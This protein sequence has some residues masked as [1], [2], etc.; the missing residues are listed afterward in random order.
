MSTNNKSKLQIVPQY[1]KN[2]TRSVKYASSEIIGEIMP[3]TANFAQTNTEVFKTLT[4]DIRNYKSIIKRTQQQI[5]SSSYTDSAKKLI[6]NFAE[7]VKSGN[8]YNKARE[9]KAILSATGWD[10]VLDT[11]DF[12]FDFDDV[13][14]NADFENTDSPLTDG[15]KVQT[16]T[17]LLTANAIQQGAAST[18]HVIKESTSMSVDATIQ[19]SKY[20]AENQNAINTTNMVFQQKMFNELNSGVLDIATNIRGIF[21]FTNNI[22]QYFNDT[23]KL[24]ETMTNKMVE[25]EALNREFTEMQRNMYKEYT[26]E[27]NKEAPK[28]KNAF[29]SGGLDIKAYADS[30]IEKAKNEFKNSQAGSMLSAMGDD[31]NFV[32]ALS[33]SPAKFIAKAIGGKLFTKNLKK[34]M[35]N[36][37]DI[38][39]NFTQAG[40][41]KFSSAMKEKGE[42]NEL[43]N[44]IYKIFGLDLGGKVGTATNN[45]I[46]GPVPFSGYD[47]KAITDVIPTYLRK[48]LAT[49]T[50]G[51]EMIYDYKRGKFLTDTDVQSNYDSDT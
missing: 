26:G 46:K 7:D 41:L 13:A 14:D 9:S 29:I 25:L 43:F 19:S 5:S 12:N 37:D 6:K 22:G 47:H 20:I 10:S 48:I 21:D 8:Y 23:A 50:G 2:V 24:T 38:F 28:N 39:K 51:K 33:G 45:Y 40:M 32:E 30:V 44:T 15:E 1:I 16:Q 3:N 34:R 11:S 27:T 18:L 17:Q 4:T 35:T 42:S 31:T 36:F 49:M